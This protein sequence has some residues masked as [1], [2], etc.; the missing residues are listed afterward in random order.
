MPPPILSKEPRR[1]NRRSLPSNSTS[2]SKSSGSPSP[3]AQAGPSHKDSEPSVSS[4]RSG[5]ASSTTNGRA[6]RSKDAL[7]EIAE[8]RP[9]R[10]SN[11]G[12]TK[13]GGKRRGKE[14]TK[15]LELDVEPPPLRAKDAIQDVPLE[16]LG[17]EDDA[18]ITRCV[19]GVLGEL[20]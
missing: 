16:E 3:D 5:A 13:R 19:C 18:G 6:K 1:S 20:S 15:Q 8:E 7:D 14:K 4:S 11:G 2:T 9:P 10:N 17:L 12:A